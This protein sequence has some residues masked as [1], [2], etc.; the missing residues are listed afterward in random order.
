[1]E[2]L[3]KSGYQIGTT[4][5]SLKDI[6]GVPNA[7]ANPL[8]KSL[9]SKFFY[10]PTGPSTMKRAA[11]DRDVCCIERSNDINVI[12]GVCTQKNNNNLYIHG[13]K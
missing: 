10:S 8:Y 7:F 1:M 3:D 13:L 6:L 9:K 2:D 12:I 11:F 5:A 4:S